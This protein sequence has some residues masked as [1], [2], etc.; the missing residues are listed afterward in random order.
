MTVKDVFLFLMMGI[1]NNLTIL[2]LGLVAQ[3][4]VTLCDPMD[5]RLMKYLVAEYEFTV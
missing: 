2:P 5:S 1:Y 4:C 3:S